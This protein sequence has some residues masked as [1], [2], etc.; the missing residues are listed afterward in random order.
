MSL[1]KFRFSHGILRFAIKKRPRHQTSKRKIHSIETHKSSLDNTNEDQLNIYS[2]HIDNAS[3]HFIEIHL[4]AYTL[5]IFLAQ[6]EN[7][8]L[9]A[10]LLYVSYR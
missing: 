3:S 8:N 4:T 7:R 9:F 5:F 2:F 10:L 1:E 6:Y